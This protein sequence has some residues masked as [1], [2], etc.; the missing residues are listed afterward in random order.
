V[1][2]LNILKKNIPLLLTKQVGSFIVKKDFLHKWIYKRLTYALAISSVI[3]KNLIDTC[4]L[5]EN[6]V[7]LLHNGIDISRFDPEKIDSHKVRNEFHIKDS[8]ILIGMIARFS[9]GKGHEE[10]LLAA[11]ELNKKYSDLKFIIVG[12]PSQGEDKYAESIKKLALKY[13]LK[14]I[15]FTGFRPDT[16][17]VL[18]AMDIF[19]FPSHSEAFGIALTEALAM[20]IPSVCS[21]ADG[22]L[23]IAV[24]GETSLLFE[25][26]NAEDLF[27]KI[28]LLIESPD[29]RKK[30]S[31]SSR[32]RAV[33]QFN[34]EELTNEV[35]RIYNSII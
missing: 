19:V 29:L 14:N 13:N 26:R 9:P 22:V 10:F 20:G 5:P 35:I 7:I 4:P 30:F 3:Q 8:E 31:I 1:P 12:E 18:A 11:K 24:E 34:I 16:P 2:A 28:S 32:K 17:E 33:E 15:I 27:N 25:N 21:N 23:D 6:K